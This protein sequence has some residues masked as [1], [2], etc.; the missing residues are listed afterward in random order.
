MK[1][2]WIPLVVIALL[3]GCVR[4]EKIGLD[5]REKIRFTSQDSYFKNNMQI[6]R[7]VGDANGR[8]IPVNAFSQ[9]QFKEALHSAFESVDLLDDGLLSNSSLDKEATARFILETE[10]I[11]V[12]RPY[13]GLDRVSEVNVRYTIIDTQLRDIIYDKKITS[14]FY[15]KIEDNYSPFTWGRTGIEKAASK[16]IHLLLE[17]LYLF[18]SASL[19]NVGMP[20]TL[21]Q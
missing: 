8:V 5:W 16:N 15:M 12:Y 3:T 4:T 11:D 17:D 19:Q 7:V 6:G 10:I 14:T 13:A 9:E 1:K 2:V 20:N 21:A 18:D